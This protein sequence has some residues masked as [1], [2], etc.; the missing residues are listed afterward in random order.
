MH[1]VIV[2]AILLF[3]G[4]WRVAHIGVYFQEDPLHLPKIGTTLWEEDE[5]SNFQFKDT[6]GFDVAWDMKFLDIMCFS[7][8]SESLAQW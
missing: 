2:D 7:I 3:T 4:I 6:R 5:V 8:I 1:A